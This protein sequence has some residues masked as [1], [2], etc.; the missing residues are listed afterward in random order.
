MS[1]TYFNYNEKYFSNFYIYDSILIIYFLLLVGE[2]PYVCPMPG[3]KKAYSNSSDRFKHTRTHTV[4][5]PYR[6][7]V[8][9]CPKRY[10]DPSSLRKHV[11]TYRHYPVTAGET[12]AIESPPPQPP[13]S[14]TAP[15]QLGVRLQQ[16]H[17]QPH[18]TFFAHEVPAN[19]RPAIPTF[20]LMDS[21]TPMM[22]AQ[23]SIPLWMSLGGRMGLLNPYCN[24]EV[25]KA[26]L[27]LLNTYCTTEVQETPLDLT[28][29]RAACV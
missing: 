12:P 11:K 16:Q 26:P 1:L 28:I 19:P 25:Q 17:Q 15:A 14:V 4:E 7:K 8:P 24:T 5:K 27:E 18:P 13:A 23:S 10:T 2:R 21:L 3:C 20:T 29:N 6:C 22:P 9:G